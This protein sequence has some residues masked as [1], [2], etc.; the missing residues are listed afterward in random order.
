MLNAERISNDTRIID[1]TVGELKGLIASVIP[2]PETKKEKKLVYGLDGLAKLFGCSKSAAYELKRSGKI[3]K[4]ITQ[5]GRK[6]VVD[7]ELALQL[8]GKNK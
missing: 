3:D 1:L 6:I 8:A 2:V 5:Q 4:A 7:S